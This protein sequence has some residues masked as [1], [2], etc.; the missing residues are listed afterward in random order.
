ML[1]RSKG[2]L[3]VKCSIDIMRRAIIAVM[4]QWAKHIK[5]DPEGRIPIYGYS[6]SFSDGK[7]GIGPIRT[8]RNDKGKEV[9]EGFHLMV[10]GPTNGAGYEAAPGN[11]WADLGL[12]QNPDRSWEVVGD[13]G[14]MRTVGMTSPEALEKIIGSEIA[15]MKALAWAKHVGAQAKVSDSADS[16]RVEISVDASTAKKIRQKVTA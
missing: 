8:I 3:K 9:P 6:S 15:K 5:A 10:P 13:W 4:P 11:T 1:F 16:V 7:R 2:K 12:K 14:G